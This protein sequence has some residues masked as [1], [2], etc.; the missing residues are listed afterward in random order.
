[1]TPHVWFMHVFVCHIDRTNVLRLCPRV[2]PADHIAAKHNVVLWIYSK[3]RP[4]AQGASRFSWKLTLTSVL[5]LSAREC[6]HSYA[7]LGTERCTEMLRKEG[8]C[9]LV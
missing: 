7:R 8:D 6:L 4:I 3:S 9:V 2:V 1:M 5:L